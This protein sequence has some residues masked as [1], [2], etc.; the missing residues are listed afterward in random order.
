MILQ[1]KNQENSKRNFDNKTE[2][3]KPNT[4]YN[5]HHTIQRT[6]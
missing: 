4:D 2:N 5:N 1:Q 6:S 3:S